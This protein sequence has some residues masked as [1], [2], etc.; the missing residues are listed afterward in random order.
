MGSKRLCDNNFI[1]VIEPNSEQPAQRFCGTDKIAPIKGK[2]NTL[3][4]RSKS[5]RDFAGTGWVLYFAAVHGDS[6]VVS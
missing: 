5:G 1:E 3:H 2:T 4:I 6:K